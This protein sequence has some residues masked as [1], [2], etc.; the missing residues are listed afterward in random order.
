MT[1]PAELATVAGMS[2]D[3]FAG[4]VALLRALAVQTE[5]RMDLWPD[6]QR[7]LQNPGA[8]SSFADQVVANALVSATAFG[9]F[10]ADCR[11]ALCAARA[12]SAI[13]AASPSIEP[14]H[15]AA[16]TASLAP[17]AFL[18]A[19]LAEW[20]GSATEFARWTDR[21]LKADPNFI[22]AIEDAAWTAGD[23]GEARSAAGLLARSGI[24]GPQGR[25]LAELGRPGKAH[26]RRNDQCPCDS[27]RKFKACCLPYNGHGP[28]MGHRWLHEKMIAFAQRPPERRLL[29]ELASDLAAGPRAEAGH[30]EIL[31]NACEPIVFDLLIWHAG[32]VERFLEARS[33]ILPAAQVSVL[34][35]WVD[36]R[37]M[38][39]EPGAASTDLPM[40]LLHQVGRSEVTSRWEGWPKVEEQSLVLAAQDAVS[41]ELLGSPHILPAA[42]ADDITSALATTD[43]RL[44]AR[45]IGTH[46]GWTASPPGPPV[47]ARSRLNHPLPRMNS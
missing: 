41:G 9:V 29:L 26:V 40:P 32:G 44:L 3:E 28:A 15:P 47:S 21:A 33:P 35:R 18:E 17:L 14:R 2:A 36:V 27:G 13:G 19:R 30:D 11:A 46:A 37:L 24:D 8:V 25:L 10:I 4:M 42:A 6:V 31:A 7:A 12:N 23:R 43:P 38:L 1:H 34:E 22:P 20:H 45:A 39:W 5:D 16:Q